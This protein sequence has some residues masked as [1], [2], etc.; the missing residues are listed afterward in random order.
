MKE[1]KSYLIYGAVALVVMLPLFA[2]GFI[3]TLDMVFT[4]ELRMPEG[5]SASW[6][7]HSLLHVINFV[8]PS[9]IIQKLLLLG[10]LLLAGVGMHRL[11]R[12]LQ[13]AK[14][15]NAQDETDMSGGISGWGIYF[16]SVLFML[17][18][19]VYSRFMAG[20][21]AVLLG[22]ALLPW[23]VRLLLQFVHR[24][25]LTSALKLGGL[26]VLIGIMSIHTLAVI[27]VLI[28]AAVILV[29]WKY[30]QKLRG[31]LRFGAVALGM[32]AILSS[33]WIIPL[34]A[35]QGSTAQTIDSFTSADAAAFET[36]GENP[37]AKIGHI[38]RLQGFWAEDREQFLLPQQVT[39]P[40]G[41]MA[42]AIIALMITG[43][44]VLWR[45]SQA[46]AV[47]FGICLMAA[48]AIAA[49]LLPMPPGY[50]EPHKMVALVALCY[51][52]FAAFG[53]DAFLRWLR[54]KNETGYV[55]GA[56][57]VLILPLLF[58]RVMLLGFHGQLKP[59]QYPAEWTATNQ[60]L[61]KDAD[62]FAVLFL[63]W[64]QYMSFGFS[65]RIIANPASKFFDK[66]IVAS[67]DPELDGAVSGQV[68]A[69]ETA[70]KNILAD[71]KTGANLADRLSEQNI[72]YILL[73]KE[74][75]YL[76]YEFVAAQPNIEPVIDNDRLTL[77]RNNAWE[78]P[79]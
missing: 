29:I 26:A 72:K 25:K 65:D 57:A 6:P 48:I 70:V 66:Q 5:L 76:E 19:F 32:F 40:W 7:F 34:A 8:M 45:K 23:F 38:L 49:G 12:L 22:Y 79:R 58:M 71:A 14:K 31:F 1:W 13:P 42:L 75:D 78:E 37:L 53:V 27:A 74:V 4:P 64:H 77:F 33:Y 3:L 43:A 10:I 56:V 35:G 62:N 68:D 44:V 46:L 69:R 11:I 30:K 17:N 2:P 52:V 41:L 67:T 15:T 55:I 39:V 59:S 54:E 63:P 21:Y 28:V 9:E 18:P 60:H 16:A 24:P 61:N 47:F 20:Q 36:R 73:A 50:R 51:C